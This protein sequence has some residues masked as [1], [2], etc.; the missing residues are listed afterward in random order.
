MRTLDANTLAA[1]Q[2]QTPQYRVTARLK[3]RGTFSSD[4]LIWREGYDFASGT[5]WHNAPYRSGNNVDG[6]CAACSLAA[7]NGL[8]QVVQ[9]AIVAKIGA[10]RMTNPTNESTW[11]TTVTPMVDISAIGTPYDA[12]PGVARNGS[13][14]YVVW[15]D[16]PTL[17]RAIS[18]DD[19]ATW[20]S[21]ATFYNGTGTYTAYNNLCLAY[22]STHAK[23]YLVCRATPTS[24]ADK[25]IGFD[26]TGTTWT[27]WGEH[28]TTIEW[29]IAGIVFSS[30][31]QLNVYMFAN[32]N[33]RK[34]LARGVVTLSGG[35]FSSYWTNH[36]VIDRGGLTGEMDYEDVRFGEGA[37]ATLMTLSES[38]GGRY[39]C[40]SAFHGGLASIYMEEPRL[41]TQDSPDDSTEWKGHAH[42]IPA[43]LSSYVFLVGTAKYFY[44]VINQVEDW[45]TTLTTR[46][47]T[48]TKYKYECQQF[49]GGRL[50]IEFPAEDKG[51]G[52]YFRPNDILWLDRRVTN[53]GSGGTET[54]V[55]R[56]Y[57]ID[58]QRKKQVLTCYDALGVLAQMRARRTRT[59]KST[60]RLLNDEIAAIISWAGVAAGTITV[61]SGSEQN[62]GFVWAGGESALS[63]LHRITDQHDH[64]FFKSQFATSGGAGTDHTTV[65]NF[66]PSASNQYTYWTTVT[67]KEDF[68]GQQ[69][70]EWSFV[71]DSLRPGVVTVVG[72]VDNF[73]N[74]AD[75]WKVRLVGHQG[76]MRTYPFYYVNRNLLQGDGEVEFH[77]DREQARLGYTI[78]HATIETYANIG[79]ELYDRIAIGD[80]PYRVY[81]IQEDWDGHILKHRVTLTRENI[82]SVRSD[83]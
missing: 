24:G 52:F 32:E 50:D 74:D 3:R 81:A 17:R 18:N 22:N 45:G 58:R 83:A 63:A 40:V 77:A 78:P 10:R 43:G 51:D 60:D 69:I 71:D 15:A 70:H 29:R 68:G 62:T 55:F 36:D 38:L 7:T 64:A 9:S 65:V 47:Y 16:G 67:E 59:F 39:H 66:T 49:G 57:R 53:V 8:L 61:G 31:T 72:V 26:G 44:A 20:G 6:L 4:P 48:P 33:S 76:N 30:T 5:N 75:Y 35:A 34:T 2:A 19:G 46:S 79:L 23:Y 21:G 80:N 42:L 41:L 56:V 12:S 11:P 82:D 25:V 13:Q 73:P 14:I 54:L 37:G 28:P 27:A 1:Q